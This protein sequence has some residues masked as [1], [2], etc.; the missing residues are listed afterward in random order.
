MDRFTAEVRKEVLTGGEYTKEFPIG[1]NGTVVSVSSKVLSSLEDEVIRVRIV[2]WKSNPFKYAN[3][4]YKLNTDVI[5][6]SFINAKGEEI[7]LET[8][9]GITL[10]M[11]VLRG[12]ENTYNLKCTH[13]SSSFIEEANGNFLRTIG[14]DIT[15]GDFVLDDGSYEGYDKVEGRITCK[16]YHLSDFA[17]MEEESIKK[18]V[19]IGGDDNEVT[20]VLLKR[21]DWYKSAGFISLLVLFGIFGIGALFTFIKESMLYGLGKSKESR[22]RAYKVDEKMST[23]VELANQGVKV[24]WNEVGP[25]D[26]NR[27]N[28]FNISSELPNPSISQISKFA[29][30]VQEPSPNPEL[31][32]ENEGKTSPKG[33]SESK[34][35]QDEKRDSLEEDSKEEE[36]AE[37]K[38]DE[39][40][41]TLSHNLRKAKGHRD[42]PR[43]TAQAQRD[44]NR[45]EHRPPLSKCRGHTRLY[46]TWSEHSDERERRLCLAA[47]EGQLLAGKVAEHASV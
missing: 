14:V 34:T 6:F 19:N 25:N 37:G 30:N 33:E 15:M 43:P 18:T 40:P 46:H 47:N 45:A 42:N 26:I 28:V 4:T 13:F 38:G 44:R 41:G 32:K 10:T 24:V 31:L 3:S 8:N 29:Q 36:G 11:P 5:S 23:S 16:Y 20:Y 27:S 39:S 21:I 1:S 9:E 22:D 12:V 35:E 17:A 7:H 2:E